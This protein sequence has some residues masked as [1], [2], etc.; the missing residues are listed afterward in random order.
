MGIDW[1]LT[2]MVDNGGWCDDNG[3]GKNFLSI[4][5]SRHLISGEHGG[6]QDSVFTLKLG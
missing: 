5:C 1:A 6:W 2:M 3:C 4:A